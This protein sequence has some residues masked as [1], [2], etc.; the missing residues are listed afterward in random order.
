MN[1]LPVLRLNVGSSIIDEDL[2][3]NWAQ[4]SALRDCSCELRSSESVQTV[5]KKV[6]NPRDNVPTHTNLNDL[7]YKMVWSTKSK[8]LEKFV[9]TNCPCNA[10]LFSTFMEVMD[11]VKGC[12]TI[13]VH[14]QK[15]HSSPV[16]TIEA[17]FDSK[18]LL[19]KH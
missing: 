17:Y 16:L 7:V 9:R 14:L 6:A 12:F 13:R 4:L 1:I 15:L 11:Q 3:T 2:K 19:S 10:T 8:A 5:L 18:V